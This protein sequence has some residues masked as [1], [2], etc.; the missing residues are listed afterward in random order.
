MT[1]PS[2]LCTHAPPYLA[3]ATLA[4]G[5]TVQGPTV[6]GRNLSQ[7]WGQGTLCGPAAL[8]W[9]AM[10]TKALKRPIVA[11]PGGRTESQGPLR[12]A[13]MLPHGQS[14]YRSNLPGATRDERALWAIPRHGQALPA[15][16][17]AGAKRLP[18]LV[19]GAPRPIG[20]AHIQDHKV[21]PHSTVICQ[22]KRPRTLWRAL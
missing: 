10:S 2:G 21:W 11:A 15:A 18:N 3:P 8:S 6:A 17:R 1:T 16:P 9:P 12:F 22:G 19:F 14:S 4:I 5:Q 13:D 20:T 7:F